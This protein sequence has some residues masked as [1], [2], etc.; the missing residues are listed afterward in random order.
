M[1]RS[2]DPTSDA[3]RYIAERK[4][5]GATYDHAVNAAWYQGTSPPKRRLRMTKTAIFL[6]VLVVVCL[7]ITMSIPAGYVLLVPDTFGIGLTF[8]A[9][10]LLVGTMVFR[11]SPMWPSGGWIWYWV[12]LLWGSSVSLMFVMLFGTS[13]SALMDKLGLDSISAS[14]AGAYPEELA[15]GFGVLIILYAF[16]QMTRPWHGFVTGGLIGLGFEVCENFLYGGLGGLIH[17]D[18]DFNGVLEMWLLRT[19]AGPGLHVFL[20]AITGYGIGYAL[21]TYGVTG[22][23]RIGVALGALLVSFLLHF[24]WNLNVNEEMWITQA[25]VVGMALYALTIVLW[26][27]AH[28]AARADRG[29]T[30]MHQPI[31]DLAQLPLS[32]AGLQGAAVEA[33]TAYDAVTVDA[34]S[35]NAAPDTNTQPTTPT[36]APP[37]PDK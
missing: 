6:L 22:R 25:L 12:S 34:T 31:T 32:I 27:K 28:R 18:S 26:L 35:F 4:R 1:S 5:Q 21:Y 24:G 23:R 15:K 37:E 36:D 29:V 20:T 8:A 3:A 16:P 13:M 10:Y 14:F 19:A 17:P 11:L 9:L 33:T 30:Y 7:P 2:V